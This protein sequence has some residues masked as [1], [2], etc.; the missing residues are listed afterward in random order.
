[1]SGLTH[2]QSEWI[3]GKRWK[4][5]HGCRRGRNLDFKC[6]RRKPGG[7]GEPS[8]EP[9]GRKSKKGG[10]RHI[11]NSGLEIRHRDERTGFHH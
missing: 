2:T 4:T 9:A 5:R 3:D 6:R 1:M 10:G 11:I 8:V 7:G